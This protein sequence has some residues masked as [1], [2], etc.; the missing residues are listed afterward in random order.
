MKNLM[1]S[2]LYLLS[3]TFLLASCGGESSTKGNWS[4]SDM[5]RCTSDMI[6]EMKDD[7][8]SEEILSLSGSTMEEFAACACEKVSEVFDSY[9]IADADESMTEEEAGMLILSCFGDLED[10]IKLGLEMED[11]SVSS[12]NLSYT[13]P[14]CNGVTEFSCPDCGDDL[15]WCE[16]KSVGE[17]ISLHCPICEWTDFATTENCS[18]CDKD[19]RSSTKFWLNKSGLNHSNCD[20]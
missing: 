13:C 9:S 6:S 11:S 14:L 12:R 10:I 20:W 17:I 8:E 19:L 3:F 16:L 1:K 5:D 18:H 4:S 2:S 7:P 15:I